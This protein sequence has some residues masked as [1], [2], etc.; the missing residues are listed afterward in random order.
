MRS[1][2]D[3]ESLS[4]SFQEMLRT[5][6]LIFAAL[7]FA[8]GS[9]GWGVYLNY[10]GLFEATPKIQI[11]S[12]LIRYNAAATI[13]DR[14]ALMQ[15]AVTKKHPH[16]VYLLRAAVLDR[17]PLIRREAV[18]L[19][20]VGLSSEAAFEVYRVSARSLDGEVRRMTWKFVESQNVAYRARLYGEV[21]KN[22][23]RIA[24]MEALAEMSREPRKE[25]AEALFR[26]WG[27]RGRRVSLEEI[28][29]TVGLWVK[30]AHG[31]IPPYPGAKK[32]SEWWSTNQKNYGE[33][34]Q[35][36]P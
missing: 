4:S 31:E 27:T 10:V 32:A 3:Q 26:D 35:P 8:V 7:V 36:M 9:M 30:H 33:K 24:A 1:S 6:L 20:S 29:Q 23:G 18:R 19:A 25:Y 5:F 22:G 15:E 11:G 21:M 14:L 2:L 16:D 28:W 12:P 13:P 17:D 34:L